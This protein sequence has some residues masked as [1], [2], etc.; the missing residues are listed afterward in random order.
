MISQAKTPAEYFA[1]LPEDRRAVMD[2]L[3][4][5]ISEHISEDFEEMMQ[6]GMVGWVVPLSVYPGGYHCTPGVPLPYMSI[7]A[8]K[9]F[10]AVYHM[11][12]Y[13]ESGDGLMDWFRT[14]YEARFGRKL[15]AGKS[16]LRFK[17]PEHIPY[18][19]IGEL[20]GKITARDYAAGYAKYDP[21]NQK[22]RKKK[23]NESEN[24]Y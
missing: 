19:L 20:A 6:Y 4:S 17:K 10:Y 24:T 9:N 1:E 15:D 2:R 21:R 16:C 5:V 7:A 22:D 12:I 11:G 23:A 13:G 3:Y 8:Q 18:D 14:E